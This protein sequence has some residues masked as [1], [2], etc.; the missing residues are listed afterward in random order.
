MLINGLLLMQRVITV[1]KDTIKPNLENVKQTC[2]SCEF[3]I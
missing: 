2:K 1:M 3:I